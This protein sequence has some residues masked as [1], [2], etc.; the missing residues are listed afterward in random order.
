MQAMQ[1]AI[2]YPERLDN[3]IVIAAASNSLLRISPSMKS[4]DTLSRPIKTFI[5]ATT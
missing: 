4:Q 2:D 5:Q 1:W 3:A